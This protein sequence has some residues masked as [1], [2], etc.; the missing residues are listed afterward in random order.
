MRERSLRSDDA[1]GRFRCL[2]ALE[3]QPEGEKDDLERCDGNGK[4]RPVAPGCHVDKTEPA[5]NAHEKHLRRLLHIMQAVCD[6]PDVQQ[7]DKRAIDGTA[8]GVGRWAHNV[9]AAPFLSLAQ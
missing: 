1:L 4:E 9:P 5:G 6:L 7:D 8:C 3:E 2:E